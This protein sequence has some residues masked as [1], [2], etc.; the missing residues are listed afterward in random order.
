MLFLPPK[1]DSSWMWEAHSS[2]SAGEGSSEPEA[3]EAILAFPNSCRQPR[4][5]LVAH[6]R[7]PG[8]QQE[9]KKFPLEIP[10]QAHPGSVWSKILAQLLPPSPVLPNCPRF[11]VQRQ[12]PSINSRV[13]IVTPGFFGDSLSRESQQGDEREVGA[14]IPCWEG[15]GDGICVLPREFQVLCPLLCGR[16]RWHSLGIN[17]AP[18]FRDN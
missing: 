5:I 8:G 16:S 1:N 4:G 18:P 12:H 2:P 7:I 9:K 14:L 11:R 3:L 6:P 17:W 10:S 15:S 13:D